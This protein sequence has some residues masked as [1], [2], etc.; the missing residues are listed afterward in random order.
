[1]KYLENFV[2]IG[3]KKEVLSKGYYWI[4]EEILGCIILNTTHYLF[5]IV[6]IGF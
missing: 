5:N 6:E 1:M 3:N 2:G 4:K